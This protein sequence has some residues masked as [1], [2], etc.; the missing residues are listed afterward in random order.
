MPWLALTVELDAPASERLSDALLDCGA[1]SVSIDPVPS[2]PGRQS[3]C[4][5]V[6]A[7]EQPERFIARAAA[8]C[9]MPAPRYSVHEIADDDWVRKSQQQFKALELQRLWIGP[10]WQAPPAGKICVR[11]DPGLAFGT[12]S[13]ASTR[14]VLQYLDQHLH[15]AGSVLDYGCGSGILAIAAAKLG[16]TRVDAVDI[17]PQAL[18]TARANA[19]L[20]GIALRAAMPE[21]LGRIRYDIVMANI[22]SQPLIVLAPALGARVADRG[23]L[24]LSGILEPQ[25]EEVIRAY[26]GL[27]E[28]RVLARDEGWALVGGKR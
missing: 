25:A 6:G 7:H 23:T 24:I 14:L 15:A 17:D 10:T 19:M 20:N 9:A 22:L 4:A 3:V 12:G 21:D 13:H 8:A 2:D 18:E 16:A 28:L 26:A 27:L 11:L 1:Q 5:L